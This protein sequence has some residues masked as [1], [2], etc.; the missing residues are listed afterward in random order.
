MYTC[1]LLIKIITKGT[2]KLVT[3]NMPTCV[4]YNEACTQ[5]QLMHID[6]GGHAVKC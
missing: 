5:L 4:T 3:S 6:I 1:S 2:T